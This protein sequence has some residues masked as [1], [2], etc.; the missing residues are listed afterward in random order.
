MCG[1]MKPPGGGSR[2]DVEPDRTLHAGTVPSRNKWPRR[3][4]QR[5]LV[6]V[7]AVI[8][9]REQVL[10]IRR[11]ASPGY[12]QWTLPGGLVE[13]GESLHEAVRREMNEEVG[14]DVRVIELSTALD[15]VL[16]DDEGQIEY[17]YVLL[18]FLCE[19]SDGEPAA[20]SDALEC[21]F[22]SLEDL[23]SYTLL[24]G[25]REVIRRAFD[26][27][28]GRRTPVYQPGM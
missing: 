16:Y 26:L 1:S 25:A 23:D 6:G 7:G 17:H 2:L 5:P 4:P 9:R 8:F 11:G 28:K 22:V 21:A 19:S 14:L 10:L 13:V 12:G 27:L 18:D 20:S 24:R 15:R 3:Y